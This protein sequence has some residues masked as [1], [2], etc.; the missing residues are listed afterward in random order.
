MTMVQDVIEQHRSFYGSSRFHRD[1][2]GTG[3][4]VDRNRVARPIGKDKLNDNLTES[5]CLT[6]TGKA[7]SGVADFIGVYSRRVGGSA[8]GII[9]GAT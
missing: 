9:M 5:R 4:K 2:S 6:A 7:N 3:L 1:L 8:M